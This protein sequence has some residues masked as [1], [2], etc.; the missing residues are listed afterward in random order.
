MLVVT[1]EVIRE[2]IPSPVKPTSKMMVAG[3]RS[4]RRPAKRRSAAK[5]SEY[6]VM[7]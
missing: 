5:Q 3:N 1:K 4:E 2:K 7:I 6:E